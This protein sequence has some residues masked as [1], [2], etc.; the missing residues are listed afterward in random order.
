MRFADVF[1][2][3]ISECVT[4]F[5]LASKWFYRV[6]RSAWGLVGHSESHGICGRFGH[7]LI[8]SP[9]TTFSRVILV[10]ELMMCSSQ[11][12]E[13]AELFA[14]QVVFCIRRLRLSP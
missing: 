2:P 3:F 10:R 8:E 13:A 5:A 6:I 1:L 11:G 4:T 12:R 7:G 14:F 9:L